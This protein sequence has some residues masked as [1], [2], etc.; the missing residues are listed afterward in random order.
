[1]L[2]EATRVVLLRDE[3]QSE[4]ALQ[5][6]FT[7]PFPLSGNTEKKKKKEKRKI[8]KN[9]KKIEKEKSAP[10]LMISFHLFSFDFLS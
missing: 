9:K 2:E 10:S 3:K 4:K 6:S 7:V 1:M 5:F 8:E